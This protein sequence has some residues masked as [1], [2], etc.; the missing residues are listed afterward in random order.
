MGTTALAAKVVEDTTEGLFQGVFTFERAQ[1]VL[2][3]AQVFSEISTFSMEGARWWSYTT[4]WCLRV[5]IKMSRTRRVGS[6]AVL[7]TR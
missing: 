4:V 3:T 2:P 5:S 1:W 6:R 7:L